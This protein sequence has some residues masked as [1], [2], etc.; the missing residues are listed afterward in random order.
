MLFR[1]THGSRACAVC[2]RRA[3]DVS[4]AEGMPGVVSCV[5]AKDVPGSNQTGPAVCD[6]TVLAEDTVSE[7][8]WHT[9]G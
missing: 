7:T 1:S 3:V 6:E 2:F 8:G 9:H 4:E 5:L